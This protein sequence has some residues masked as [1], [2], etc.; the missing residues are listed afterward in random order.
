MFLCRWGLGKIGDWILVV[1]Y[2]R[3][4]N[5][6]YFFLLNEESTIVHLIPFSIINLLHS[7]YSPVTP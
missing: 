6:R 1:F 3:I 7:I 4:F 5:A 2:L